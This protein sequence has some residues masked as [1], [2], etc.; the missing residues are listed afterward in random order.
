MRYACRR[1]LSIALAALLVIPAIGGNAIAGNAYR[2]KGKPA[3]IS[4]S[5][6][7]VTPRRDW[8]KLGISPGKNTETWTLDGEE[9]ND[10]TFFAG[11]EPGHPLFR[12]VSKSKKPLPKL[13]KETLLIEIPE[14]LENS[15]RSA[16][17]I[18][19]FSVT[20]SKAETFLGHDGIRFS[21]DYVEDTLTRRGEGRATLVNGKLYMA[22]YAAPRL[23]YYERSYADFQDLTN[24]A[25]LN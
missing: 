19:D 5:S 10:I 8:N 4:G 11:I 22:V 15:Y 16:K 21:F 7:T 12:E 17:D 20:S 18:A 6:L 14:L 2:E 23:S 13:T 3:A 25:Q 24:T 1:A 9:L